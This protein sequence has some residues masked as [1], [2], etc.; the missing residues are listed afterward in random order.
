MENFNSIPIPIQNYLNEHQDQMLFSYNNKKTS[1]FKVNYAFL[2]KIDTKSFRS[3]EFS[4]DFDESQ[5]YFFFITKSKNPNYLKPKIEKNFL[6][7][8]KLDFKN[9]NIS[10]DFDYNKHVL[11][12]NIASIKN[13]SIEITNKFV[14]NRE[15][16]EIS[17]SNVESIKYYQITKKIKDKRKKTIFDK[18][19]NNLYKFFIVEIETKKPISETTF[20]EDGILS[21]VYL[22]IKEKKDILNL[23]AIIKYA[24]YFSKETQCNYIA[25]Y[26]KDLLFD[27][28]NFPS[29]IFSDFLANIGAIEKINENQNILTFPLKNNINALKDVN[30]NNTR[31][32]IYLNLP[33]IM[34]QKAKDKIPFHKFIQLYEKYKLFQNEDYKIKTKILNKEKK[35]YEFI[36]NCLIFDK[37]NDKINN[38]HKV[39]LH[40]LIK[41]FLNKIGNFLQNKIN[42]KETIRRFML[43]SLNNYINQYI[44]FKGFYNIDVVI[45]DD[46]MFQIQCFKSK[47]TNKCFNN[48]LRC[49]MFSLLDCFN[50]GFEFNEGFFHKHF[51]IFDFSYNFNEKNVIHTFPTFNDSSKKNKI[52]IFDIPF[53]DKWVFKISAIILFIYENLFNFLNENKENNFNNNENQINTNTNNNKNNNNNNNNDNSNN[54]DNN[55]N[56]NDNNN[57]DNNSKNNDNKSN[58]NDNKINN[59]SNNKNNNIINNENNI[60]LQN[61]TNNLNILSDLSSDT[62]KL[63]ETEIEWTS[64]Q[65]K[66]LELFDNLIINI[67]GDISNNYE[68]VLPDYYEFCLNISEFPLEQYNCIDN[69]CQHFANTNIEVLLNK[70]VFF[71]IPYKSV[72]N[73]N[74]NNS[75]NI[76]NLNKIIEPYLILADNDLYK[77][78][79]QKETKDKFIKELEIDLDKFF[80]FLKVINFE[81]VHYNVFLSDN[82]TNVNNNINNNIITE[83]ENLI[84]T[85]SNT[86]NNNNNDNNNNNNN[87]NN[88][89]YKIIELENYNEF[90]SKEIYNFYFLFNLYYYFIFKQMKKMKEN[91]L[92][93]DY[94]YKYKQVKENSVEQS[95]HDED[96]SIIKE[97]KKNNDNYKETLKTLKESIK[98]DLLIMSKLQKLTRRMLLIF[99]N[100]VKKIIQEIN[101]EENSAD[102]N[103][104]KIGH[105]LINLKSFKEQGNSMEEF[106]NSDFYKKTFN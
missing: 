41:Y 7:K 13:N 83:N 5:E 3:K 69:L 91:F 25:K 38:D 35:K 33:N 2:K 37:N 63:E 34:R 77:Y 55:S 79:K 15:I 74:E 86:N 96:K 43:E 27:F 92:N 23:F 62:L 17:H 81:K 18:F 87:N 106:V 10:F 95:F 105:F 52:R 85:D 101:S 73:V 64:E 75:Y 72:F 45:N 21:V 6:R 30:F 71:L 24:M 48:C 65:K 26:I 28:C 46:D 31:K 99:Y 66:F 98:K 68:K 94:V 32:F 12:G 97:M 14:L 16:C 29:E 78:L 103:F 50:K 36:K 11:T 42:N 59:N 70:N 9:K 93:Y 88:E 40:K 76:P 22:L 89:N 104:I 8:K 1:I 58:N 47:K 49:I 82:K 84:N 80:M 61:S 100:Y 20:K 19:E 53:N 39:D 54:N 60:I 56:N 90:M 4:F 44:L 67:C 51:T 102:S 57:N